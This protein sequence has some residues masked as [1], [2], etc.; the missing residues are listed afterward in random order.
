M[1]STIDKVLYVLVAYVV[2][3]VL[4]HLHHTFYI[5]RF[6]RD[7]QGW[8]RHEGERERRHAYRMHEEDVHVGRTADF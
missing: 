4:F 8:A 6:Y 3:S 2:I 5:H 7:G 1:T